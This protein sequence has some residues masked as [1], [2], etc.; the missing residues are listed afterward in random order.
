MLKRLYQF[1]WKLNKVMKTFGV[2]RYFRNL[3]F[4]RAPRSRRSGRLRLWLY[5][6][7]ALSCAL[8]W[9]VQDAAVMAQSLEPVQRTDTYTITGSLMRS[10]ISADS[11]SE[12]SAADTSTYTGDDDVFDDRKANALLQSSEYDELIRNCNAVLDRNALCA[13]ARFYRGCAYFHQDDLRAAVRDFKQ[14]SDDDYFGRTSH[15]WLGSAYERLKKYQTSLVHY[16]E[17]LK[18]GVKDASL[19]VSRG[20]IM[21]LLGRWHDAIDDFDKAIELQPG[22]AL[23]LSHR[24]YAYAKLSNFEEALSDFSA[25]LSIDSG[26][27]LAYNYRGFVLNQRKDFDAAIED[28]TKA[29]ELSPEYAAAYV[30]RG[31]AYF[32]KGDNERADKDFRKAKELDSHMRDR[33]PVL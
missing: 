14:T 23:S 15:I 18:G 25:A 7:G 1:L 21:N 3:P 26:L 4:Q 10:P 30:N 6:T 24:G 29:V 27:S 31:C 19:L 5:I 11:A 22:N 33:R 32:A 28:F 9:P 8:C 16:S 13:W 20:C 12:N 2:S 17:A